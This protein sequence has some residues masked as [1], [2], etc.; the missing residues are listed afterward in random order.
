MGAKLETWY[1]PEE[2]GRGIGVLGKY[3]C[4]VKVTLAAAAVKNVRMV[5][6]ITISEHQLVRGRDVLEYWCQINWHA[7]ACVHLRGYTYMHIIIFFQEYLQ[8]LCAPMR[9]KYLYTGAC[10]MNPGQASPWGIWTEKWLLDMDS[11]SHCQ[12]NLWGQHK[13]DHRIELYTET[14]QHA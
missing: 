8:C 14:R 12:E 9:Q 10:M 3:E 1:P 2:E 5:I 11:C 13:A 6:R 7:V 4:S